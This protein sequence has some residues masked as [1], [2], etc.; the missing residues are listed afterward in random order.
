M[1]KIQLLLLSLMFCVAS[2]WAQSPGNA[3][4]LKPT[5]FV[6][7][8]TTVSNKKSRSYYSLSAEEKSVVNLSGPGVLRVMTRGRFVPDEDKD[9]RYEILFTVDG[10][11]Q[12]HV[13]F[14]NVGRSKKTT[15]Q[16][17]S[18]GVPGQLEDFEI[19]L[20]RGNHTIELLL[21]E[22]GIP[23]AARY[24]LTPTKEKK[25]DWIRFSPLPPCE[26]VDL[27]TKEETVNY[28]RFSLDKPLRV[29]IIGPTQ[30]RVLTRVEN[31][32][33][34]KGRI[35]YRVQIKENDKVIN[36][37]QLSSRRSEVTVYEDD[38]TLIPGKGCE[39]VIDVP[40]GNHT[41]EILSLDQDK[42]TVLGRLLIP[43]KDVNL[44]K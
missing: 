3:R 29:E 6:K 18:F 2:V 35:Q 20:G 4:Y 10:G 26:P 37:Y 43:K 38:N 44:E 11:E 40:K 22:N 17:G 5:S 30:L 39:F 21:K 8:V 28:Y 9:I 25:L 27:I 36:T 7:K 41:Y 24:K 23:V 13:Q 34:M 32:H 12:Q 33:H 15:Y 14:S 1:K 42:N 19:D 31:H 16:N